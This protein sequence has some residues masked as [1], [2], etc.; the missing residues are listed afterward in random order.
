MFVAQLSFKD[1]NEA[2]Q[3][4]WDYDMKTKA[5]SGSDQCRT[6][7]YLWK[8]ASVKMIT[9]YETLVCGAIAFL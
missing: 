7:C 4:N 1:P 5:N 6:N 9:T 3:T 8:L 2:M